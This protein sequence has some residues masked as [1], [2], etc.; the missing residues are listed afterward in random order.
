MSRLW[1]S[2]LSGWSAFFGLRC[3]RC[4]VK[5]E[6]GDTR[7]GECQEPVSRTTD[8]GRHG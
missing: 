8:G 4:G 6:R 5:L 7:C 2:L 1:N 3:D